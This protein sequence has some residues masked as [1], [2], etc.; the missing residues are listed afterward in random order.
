MP[1]VLLDRRFIEWEDQEPPDPEIH[2]AFGLGEVG[3]A[4][5]E[6]LLKRRAVILAEAGSG[7]STEMAERAR[8]T[9]ASD[10]Y[11]F[12]AT[13]EDVG[14]EGLE[15]ALSV[16]L[17]ESLKAWRASTDEAWF[18]IDSVDEAKT[19][20]MRPSCRARRPSTRRPFRARPSAT[21]RS[22]SGAPCDY[23]SIF[24][25]LRWSDFG[26]SARQPR[27][28]LSRSC[29]SKSP[30]SL[31]PVRVSISTSSRCGWKPWRKRG[32]SS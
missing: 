15:G 11:A 5:D 16:S 28:N 4:W 20:G 31:A 25:R 7:K 30:A 1:V 29:W 14:P 2:R 24:R 19:S 8:M 3:V 21:R 32:A 18:F 27:M 13:V 22:G 17:R 9:A 23:G 12:P 6:L 10:R 26:C